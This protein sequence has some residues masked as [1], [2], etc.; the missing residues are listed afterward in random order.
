MHALVTG[1]TGFVGGHLAEHLLDQGDVVTGCSRR[2]EWPA[3]LEHLRERVELAG[4]DLSDRPATLRFFER[5]RFDGV[6]H[7]A[8]MASPRE[9]AL[10]PQHAHRENT[11]AAL[12]VFEAVRSCAPRPRILLVSSSY[13]YGQPLPSDLPV[14]TRCPIR[15]EQVYAATK[16]AAELLSE[17]YGRAYG[18]ESVRVRPFNHTGP[19]QQPGYIVPDWIKQVAAIESGT[20]P[21]VLRVGDLDT[22]RDYTDVRDV[23]KAYRL[24]LLKA[25]SHTVY[26]L[27]SGCTRTG[28]ELLDVLGGLSRVPWQIQ[29]D[30]GRLRRRQPPE[31][32]AD[33]GPLRE[34][35]GW[36]PE[37]DLVST[38]RDTLDY[39]RAKLEGG[40]K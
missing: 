33:A 3:E 36:K 38:L 15:I 8:G 7:L 6:F 40:N 17:H 30:P 9:C 16:W 23:V 21:P 35:T 1:I 5:R 13:V 14:S 32:V 4:C 37:I 39:W 18:V 24:L 28:R 22:R 19:R 20:L 34:L 31:I 27:G 12:H 29:T 10:H 26:N 11:E 2:G 25:P